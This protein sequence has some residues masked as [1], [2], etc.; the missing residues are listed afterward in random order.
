M[1]ETAPRTAG[2]HSWFHHQAGESHEELHEVLEGLRGE[3]V[4]VGEYPPWLEDSPN[5]ISACVAKKDSS[6]RQVFTEVSCVTVVS[7]HCTQN[8]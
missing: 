1:V 3:G 2:N 6:V 8:S 7:R 4:A 5:V